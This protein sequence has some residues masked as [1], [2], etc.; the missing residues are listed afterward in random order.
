MP[1]SEDSPFNKCSSCGKIVVSIGRHSC[2][3]LSSSQSENYTDSKPRRDERIK[4]A[5]QDQRDPTEFVLVGSSAGNKSGYAY[6]ELDKDGEP[7]HDLSGRT[8]HYRKLT[9]KQAWEAS[10]SPCQICRK[11]LDKWI[12]YRQNT[13]LW[14][15]DSMASSKIGRGDSLS[16]VCFRL[17]TACLMLW[18]VYMVVLS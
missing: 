4:K 17:F 12:P 18:T 1:E 5:A 11:I 8:D 3:V 2:G 15:I 16:I 9:R 7:L 13:M 14:W 10:K 6:H